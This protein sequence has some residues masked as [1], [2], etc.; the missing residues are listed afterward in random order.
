MDH[1][2]LA[3][4]DSPSDRNAVCN[5]HEKAINECKGDSEKGNYNRF[6]TLLPHLDTRNIWFSIL[7][8]SF[9][10]DHNQ[11]KCL[12]DNGQGLLPDDDCLDCSNPPKQGCDDDYIMDPLPLNNCTKITCREPG[13]LLSCNLIQKL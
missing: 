13:N 4:I 11:G 7:K 5:E 8:I 6:V 2:S 10:T 1:T 9:F 12:E 3:Q